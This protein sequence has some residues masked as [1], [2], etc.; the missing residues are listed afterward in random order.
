[1][2]TKKKTLLELMAEAGIQWPEGAEY[3]AQDND[4][5]K[6]YFFISKPLRPKEWDHWSCVGISEYGGEQLPA[7]CQNW[8]QTIITKAQYEKALAEQAG[9]PDPK[10]EPEHCKSVMRTIHGNTIEQRIA[11]LRALEKHVAEVRARLTDDLHAMGVTWLD[12]VI[13]IQEAKK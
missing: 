3:A 13:N 4:D 7:L 2:T 10:P 5:M 12:G 9:E 11:E 1:M 8:H 6:L